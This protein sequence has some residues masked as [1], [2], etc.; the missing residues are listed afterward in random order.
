[1]RIAILA[2]IHGNL[3]AFEAA[4]EHVS[5]QHVD[6]IIIAGDIVVGSPDSAA[7]WQLAQTLHCP[8]LRGNHERYVAFYGTSDAD[9]Q[10]NTEQFG[11][12]RWAAAQF[13][14]AERRSM[15][16][17]PFTLRLPDVPDVLVVHAS[18]RN[19]RDTVAAYT[20]EDQLTAMFPDIRERVI[21][22]AHN[23]TGQVRLW[24]DRM[25]I[26][27]GS[28]GLPLDGNPTAQYLLLEQLSERWQIRH[29]S[30]AYN[31]DVALQRFYETNYL[32]AAGPIGRLYLREVATASYH[33]VPFLRAYS[34][35]S[36][37]ADLSLDAAVERF[38][39][40]H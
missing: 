15:N 26:T 23:H 31:L 34:Q 19:D 1:M 30:V 12:V 29:Q 32:T 16:D 27:A 20:P 37:H 5:H 2:D 33:V 22:R 10:W 3:P 13:T 11:P 25:I 35:W 4:L 7:C 6:Q 18:L 40:M 8:I 38:L 17:L 36:S 24:G 21:V 39:V 9:P 14:D 28:V